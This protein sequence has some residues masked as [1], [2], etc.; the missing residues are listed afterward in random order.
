MKSFFLF[1]NIKIDY[2]V[3]FLIFFFFYLFCN[4]KNTIIYLKRKRKTRFS[5]FSQL[6]ASPK[7]NTKSLLI[8]DP[9]VICI[10]FYNNLAMADEMMTTT[11]PK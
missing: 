6:H 10:I 1:K 8:F 2:N 7:T 5:V 3:I 4:E 9:F 11:I